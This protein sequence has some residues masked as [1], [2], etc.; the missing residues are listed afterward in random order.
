MNLRVLPWEYGIRNLLRRPTRSLLTLGALA[1]V[2]ILILVTVG[3]IQGLTKT[4]DVSGGKQTAI[5]F[6]INMG[7]NLEYSSIP[8]SS[9]DVVAGNV[10]GITKTDGVLDVSSELFMGTQLQL[11]DGSETFGLLRG[12]TSRVFRVRE[13]VSIT[14]GSWPEPGEILVGSMVETKQ[15]LG[16]KHLEVG[17]AIE[18]EG[19]S[20]K[21]S[22]RFAAGGSVFESEI[23]CRLTDLQQATRR[24]DLSLVAIKC[25]DD[26]AFSKL[27]L[28]CRQR[29]DLELQSVAEREYYATL[30]RDYAPIRTLGWTM[31]GLISIAGLFAGL[32]TMFGAVIGRTREMAM[33]QAIGY[34]RR[35][36]M[37]SV[38]QEGVLL[39][40]GG[41]IIG[42]L[43]SFL[44]ID[45]VAIR[46]TMGAFELKVDQIA[47]LAGCAAGFIMGL[48]GSLIPGIRAMKQDIVLGLKSI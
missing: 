37:L 41:A 42:A 9:G 14:E 24:E 10:A 48:L 45:G 4:L 30:Q 8:M 28:F 6:S 18:L 12:V 46:F 3:F 20:W 32:N 22:G 31:V 7:E 1:I 43:V 38:I 21:I 33:L 34:S 2:S 15:G 16:A 11:E 39:G 44:W 19:E 5:V 27:E 29:Y 26:A 40:M 35:A 17:D 13:Q 47:V 23:W 25:E 36:I